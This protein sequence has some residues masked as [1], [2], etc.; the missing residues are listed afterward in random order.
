MFKWSKKSQLKLSMTVAWCALSVA[1][2]WP[3]LRLCI[4]VGLCAPPV[5]ILS[6]ELT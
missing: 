6:M 3:Q 1:Y 5:A 2:L 4:P